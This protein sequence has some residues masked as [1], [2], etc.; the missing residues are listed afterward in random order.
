MARNGDASDKFIIVDGSEYCLCCHDYPVWGDAEYIAKNK[1][2]NV[3]RLLTW[4]SE[5]AAMAVLPYVKAWSR[6][7]SKVAIDAVR[8][9]Q[10]QIPLT[11]LNSARADS[12]MMPIIELLKK[13]TVNEVLVKNGAADEW[14]LVHRVG[15]PEQVVFTLHANPT[16]TSLSSCERLVDYEYWKRGSRLIVWNSSAKATEFATERWGG[17]YCTAHRLAEYPA[18]A[19]LGTVS[20]DAIE[21]TLLEALVKNGAPNSPWMIVSPD[22]INLRLLYNTAA[23]RY[24]WW[25]TPDTKVVVWPTKADAERWLRSAGYDTDHEARP[26][27]DTSNTIRWSELRYHRRDESV[28]IIRLTEV[29]LRGGACQR[30]AIAITSPYPDEGESCVG[31]IGHSCF[32]AGVATALSLKVLRSADSRDSR[33]E[34]VLYWKTRDSAQRA[35]HSYPRSKV[36]DAASLNLAPEWFVPV[37]DYAHI[38]ENVDEAVL[39]NGQRGRYAI[40]DG[41]TEKMCLV[42]APSF[43]DS[44][45]WLTPRFVDGTNWR[46]VIWP[47]VAAAQRYTNSRMPAQSMSRGKIVDIADIP[48]DPSVTVLYDLIK[49]GA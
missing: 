5:A 31:L 46:T 1:N 41:A 30:Y 29:V 6:M 22:E 4:D 32:Y 28:G 27:T 39:L 16:R 13:N 19:N 48:I 47:T 18:L 9:S 49:H 3:F 10:L 25:D 17:E 36:V 35:A 40:L 33:Y 43:G 21:H 24:T 45:H 26:C 42:H 15:H 2:P 11:K 14:I 20:I 44:L 8:P 12:L 7:P 34:R 23:L 37:E 38:L